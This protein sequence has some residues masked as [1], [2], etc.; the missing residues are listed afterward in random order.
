M[1]DLHGYRVDETQWKAKGGGGQCNLAVKDGKRYFIKRLTWPRYPESDKF[2][3]AFRQQKIDVCNDWMKTRKQIMRSIPGTGT[4]TLIKPIE[5][6]REGPCYY[7]VAHFVEVSS[8]PYDQVYKESRE[9]KIRIMLTV[10]MSLNDLHKAGVVHADLDPNNILI[11]KVA[12]SNNLA[13]K[14]IDF[15]DSFFEKDPP[16]T[17][18]SKDFW[19]SPEVAMYSKMAANGRNPNPCRSLISCKADVYTLGIIFHQY[20]AAGRPPLCIKDQPWQDSLSGNKP[21]IDPSVEEDFRELISS[22]LEL[23]PSQRPSMADVHRKLLEMLKP[24]MGRQ[25]HQP[26]PAQPLHQPEPVQ[27]P[28]QPEPIVGKPFTPVPEPPRTLTTGAGVRSA[29]LHERNP[30]KVCLVFEN[31]RTQIMD[32]PLAVRQG[33]VIEE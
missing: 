7:E 3:G 18:M 33:Y 9:T 30:K 22:M 14:L 17:I 20:C 8:I 24:G 13:T 19:W 27:P 1:Q 23:E 28:R 32:L 25:A 2:K 5:Y 16:E 11:S 12:G 31:G 15:T 29:R 21:C 6:F 26:E 10:A 4:G